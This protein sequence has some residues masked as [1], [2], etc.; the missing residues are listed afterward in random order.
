L[1]CGGGERGGCG[2]RGGEIDG[3]EFAEDVPC[4]DE[5]VGEVVVGFGGREK[6]IAFADRE[7]ECREEGV[8]QVVER[9]GRVL[10]L[11]VWGVGC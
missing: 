6:D 1:G 7:G 4:F 2:G 11:D 5:L 10:R 9:G 8:Q 3:L